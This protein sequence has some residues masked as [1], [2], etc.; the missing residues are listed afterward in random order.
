M[1]IVGRKFLLGAVPAAGVDAALAVTAQAT[2]DGHADERPL[3]ERPAKLRRYLTEER[4]DEHDGRVTPSCRHVAEVNL[5]GFGGEL[6]PASR[7]GIFVRHR[8]CVLGW[9]RVQHHVTAEE[10]LIARL[11]FR[12]EGCEHSG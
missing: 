11:V 1:H 7:G 10:C 6:L 4:R 2:L 8:R 5:R 9:E 3:R 12:C